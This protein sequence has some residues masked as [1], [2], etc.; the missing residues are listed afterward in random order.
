MT[1]GPLLSLEDAQSRLLALARP[2]PA[3]DLPV[4]EASGRWLAGDVTA[5]RSQ[6]PDCM[7]AMDGYAVRQADMPGPWQVIGESAAG[8]PFQGKV[9]PGEAVRI[10]T[11]AVLPAGAD[12]VAVQEDCRREGDSLLFDG[13]APEPLGRHIRPRGLDFMEGDIVCRAGER[14]TPARLALAI[15][16][17]HGKLPV[18]GRAN[19]AIIESGDEL[20]AA[21]QDL[22]LGAIPASNGTMLGS[23][24]ADLGCEVVQTGPV[25]DRRE[26]LRSAFEAAYD[27]DLIVTSGGA[28]VGDHDLVLPVLEE[29]GARIDF[30]RVAI[31]PGKPILVASLD[32]RMV[33]GL[34]G[35][36]VSSFVT[37]HLFALPLARPAAHVLRGR[38][39]R[40]RAQD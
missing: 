36:P 6:P 37:A 39:T 10:A 3:T 38:S 14:L 16:A 15:C 20:R 35:N 40:D 29:M 21:G 27:A 8:H 2:L 7:S 12:M 24:F 22:P 26:A 19:V 23:L 33:I 17:G 32:G 31:K 25:P 13:E 34:P 5:L 11:G 30:W 1:P 28:S 18:H 4:A 9:G